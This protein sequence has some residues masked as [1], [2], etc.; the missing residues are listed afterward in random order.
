MDPPLESSSSRPYSQHSQHGGLG[1]D[2]AQ[3][4][5]GH[6]ELN[7]GRRGDV[8]R[9][10][11]SD[12]DMLEHG[13]TSRRR[14]S[15]DRPAG[16]IDRESWM[17]SIRKPSNRRQDPVSRSQLAA[18]RMAM[19]AADRKRRSSEHPGEFGGRRT[20]GSLSFV[21][22]P[23]RSRH[24]SSQDV[25][26][27]PSPKECST[28]SARD[29]SSQ[30]ITDHPLPRRPS[31]DIS[32]DRRSREITLPRWQPDIEVSK[33]PIC[34][35][36]FSFWHRKH[37][38][39]KCGRVVCANC[40]PHR[41]TI[42]RQFIVHPPEESQSTTTTANTRVDIVDLTGDSDADDGLQGTDERPQSS[43]YRIDPALGGGQE[44]RL[45]NPCVPDP[46]PL[47]HLPRSSPGTQPHAFISRPDLSSSI[48]GRLPAPVLAA[49][50]L[51][52]EPPLT[53]H[54]SSNR[55]G[56]Q[57]S[58]IPRFDGSTISRG[59]LPGSATDTTTSRRHSHAPRPGDPPL[60][61]TIYPTMY[62]SAPDQTAD[63]VRLHVIVIDSVLIDEASSCIS[64]TESCRLPPPPSTC[65]SRSH[66]VL[67]ST[68]N[69]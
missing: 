6:P 49:S 38:C 43:D 50:G 23:N 60:G 67:V 8:L 13:A 4:V 34:N 33:C 16:A 14:A 19:M 15:T 66:S 36:A 62:G 65:L 29:V 3:N 37:H 63:R 2:T 24:N 58:N 17:E 30:R 35:T 5:Q 55:S 10:G 68:F 27:Q 41:I 7:I 1:T 59:A 47:P 11:H 56:Y 54:V 48:D 57:H 61:S 9:R 46:N 52:R 31:S 42:P 12:G 20:S 22:P 69:T 51:Y 45:C 64:S 44:V 25:S 28:S 53:R 40:S 18:S 21:H 39:R 32:H 26:G